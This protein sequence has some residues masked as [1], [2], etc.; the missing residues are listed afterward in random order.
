MKIVAIL[1]YRGE[2]LQIEV[3]KGLAR[4]GTELIVS[5]P[6]NYLQ[7]D[8]RNSGGGL[9]VGS[10]DIPIN[11]SN[12]TDGEIIEHSKDADYIFVFWNRFE[13][14]TDTDPGGR[15]YLVDMINQPDKTV[16]IDGS[17][18]SYSGNKTSVNSGWKNWKDS[19]NY[20]KGSPWIWQYMRDRSKWYFKR[21]T[22]PEDVDEHNI[23]PCPYPFRVE[24]RQEQFMN[25]DKDVDIS[26]VFGQMNTGLRAEVNNSCLNLRNKFPSMSIYVGPVRPRIKCLELISKS[27]LHIDAWGGGMCTVRRIESVMNETAIIGQKWEIIAP[28]DFTDGENIINWETIEEFE[29]KVNYYFNNLDKVIEIGKNSYKHALKYHTTE[30]RLKYIFDVINGRLKWEI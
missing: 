23:I 27:K 21:E 22:F 8:Y 20:I 6:L 24:D 7:D 15:M 28:N 12:Y 1:G 13:K 17:E 16:V 19:R 29:E 10:G 26:C 5:T 18:W 2:Y 11:Q 9:D 14:S 30:K 4:M 25:L 3:L